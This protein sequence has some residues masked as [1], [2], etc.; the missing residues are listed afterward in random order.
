MSSEFIAGT[1]LT[2]EA[3]N[4]AFGHHVDCNGGDQMYGPLFMWDGDGAGPDGTDYL[5]GACR[6]WT[7]DYVVQAI[8]DTWTH[9]PGNII[10]LPLTGGTLTG[11]LVI[12]PPAAT[13]NLT[14]NSIG[15]T[16]AA[17]IQTQK[18]GVPIW[19]LELG[20]ASNQF[21]FIRFDSSGVAISP[22]ALWIVKDTGIVG[23]GTGITFGGT[24]TSTLNGTFAGNPTFIGQP[25]FGISPTTG[26]PAIVSYNGDAGT[27]RRIMWKTAGVG[28]WTN[29]LI[30]AES[31][32]DVGS[33]WTL[34]RFSDAGANIGAVIS[35]KRSNGAVTF[36]GAGQGNTILTPGV[37]NTAPTTISVTGTGGL[38]F[39]STLRLGFFGATPILKPTVTGAKGSNAALA[40]LLT[41]LASLGIV[42]DSSTA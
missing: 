42:T 1:E 6:G 34:Y 38:Q 12:Q 18:N 13:A 24:A 30:N 41:Q 27:Y 32:G 8:Y 15:G 9:P 3:L 2:A 5:Q 23:F 7:R 4:G 21:N 25:T 14:L 29:D 10:Y 19:Q 40:S 22:L 33:D 39:L 31:T 28:R 11:N 37:P 16:F 20:N 35:F 36:G 26:N 17:I